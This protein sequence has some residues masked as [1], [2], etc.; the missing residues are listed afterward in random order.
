VVTGSGGGLVTLRAVQ[1]IPRDRWHA[2]SAAQ[3]MLPWERLPH[4]DPD[5]DLLQA[6]ELLERHD[7]QQLPVVLDG[8]VVGLASREQMLRLLHDAREPRDEQAQ[9]SAI[10][11]DRAD[12]EREH[13]GR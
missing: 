13:T 12:S 2:V 10:T 11:S 3:V 7:L 8:R 9:A 6:L 1:A 5:T 4:V